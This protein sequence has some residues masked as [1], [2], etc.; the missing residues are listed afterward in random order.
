MK[1]DISHCVWLSPLGN[2]IAQSSD[3]QIMIFMSVLESLSKFM[4]NIIAITSNS[5]NFKMII[6]YKFKIPAVA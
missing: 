2:E 6:S 5:R 3:E 1:L 4:S